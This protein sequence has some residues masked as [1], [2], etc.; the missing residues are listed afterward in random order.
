M[1]INLPQWLG[2]QEVAAGMPKE[3]R[4][5]F[6]TDGENDTLTF[7]SRT[8]IVTIKHDSSTLVPV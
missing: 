8:T 6:E 7:E 2:M 1:Q 5:K 3:L 4:A